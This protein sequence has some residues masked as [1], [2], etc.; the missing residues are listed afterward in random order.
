MELSE[1]IKNTVCGSY[2]NPD[3]WIYTH[4]DNGIYV[5]EVCFDSGKGG[6]EVKIMHATDLHFN[7]I[8]EKDFDNEEV[9]LTIRHRFWNANGAAVISTKKI[10]EYGKNF[11]QTV[12][13]GDVLD[14]LSFGAM[15][16]MDKYVWDKDPNVLVSVG[17]HEF[18]YQ[19]QTGVKDKTPLENRYKIVADFWRHD[20]YYT[21]KI[22]KDKVMVIQLDNSQHKYW[23]HQVEK[24]END[25]NTARKNGYV[26]LI[27]Q[28][29]PLCTGN[30]E[31]TNVQ[32]VRE[33]DGEFY[34]FYEKSVGHDLS[35]EATAKMYALLTE[36]ADVIKGF[37]CGHLHSTY[38]T[39]VKGSY[40]DENG[41]VH[42]VYIPQ[43]V[44]EGAVYDDYAG[45]IIEITVK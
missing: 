1:K 4:S 29:D 7:Y 45:H 5:H 11:D 39:R 40:S 27:F 15:E 32:A 9:M 34:N 37:F 36:N 22:L 26:V 14:Y 43:Y 35:D 12:I 28:H 33:Y 10:M 23:E 30:P 21:S 2:E 19:M 20:I 16:L 44:L 3:T 31:D 42:E 24:L 8:N 13:T 41:T 17:G 38:F 25:I 6:E 18:L